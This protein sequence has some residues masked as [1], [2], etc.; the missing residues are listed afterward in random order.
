MQ[1]PTNVF[2]LVSSFRSMLAQDPRPVPQG[3]PA[4]RVV[5]HA[6][7]EP[8]EATIWSPKAGELFLDTV[9]SRIPG[10]D[11]EWVVDCEHWNVH[12]TELCKGFAKG[13]SH[14]W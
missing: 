2:T 12:R 3:G 6:H 1:R 8:R 14:R 7:V 4:F 11:F 9:T 13:S 5:P 10:V